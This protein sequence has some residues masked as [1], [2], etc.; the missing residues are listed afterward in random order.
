MPCFFQFP[1][2]SFSTTGSAAS[3]PAVSTNTGTAPHTIY[4]RNVERMGS[5]T[6]TGTSHVTESFCFAPQA[7]CVE[8]WLTNSVKGELS[9]SWYSHARGHTSYLCCHTHMDRQVIAVVTHTH[10][11]RQASRWRNI[12][13]RHS[14]HWYSHTHMN[15][16]VIDIVTYEQGGHTH[17]AAGNWNTY[18]EVC[19]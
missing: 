4:T 11:G 9:Q 12:H 13:K 14:C 19:F 1:P 18:E 6:R 8:K 3:S 7:R 2:P 5:R 16:Q 15:A 10:M 17:E